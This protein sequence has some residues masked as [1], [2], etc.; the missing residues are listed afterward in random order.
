MKWKGNREKERVPNHACVHL[1]LRHCRF[2]DQP[3]F[4][5]LSPHVRRQLTRT[6]PEDIHYDQSPP[7]TTAMYLTQSMYSRH[8]LVSPT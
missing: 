1:N 6:C 8:Y 3:Y 5:L 4:R 2:G 7:L